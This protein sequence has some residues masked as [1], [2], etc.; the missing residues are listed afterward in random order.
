MTMLF[1]EDEYRLELEEVLERFKE[2]LSKI[3]TG[4][5]SISVFQKINVDSYGSPMSLTAVAKLIVDGPMAVR[6]EVW[7]KNNTDSVMEALSKVDLGARVSQEG[8]VIRVNFVPLTQEDRKEKSDKLIPKLLNDFLSRIR[9]IRRSYNE[10]VKAQ[11]KVSEDDQELSYKVIQ[12]ILKEYEEIF[13]QLAKDKKL[14][15]VNL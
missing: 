6:L 9:E 10:K 5:A 14:E 12:E 15:L 7:D 1:N 3:R 8:N 2:E 11:E 4:K 13:E